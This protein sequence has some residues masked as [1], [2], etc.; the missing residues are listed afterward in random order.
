MLG[1]IICPRC[2]LVQGADLSVA[3]TTCPR[4]QKRIEVRRAKIYF[5]TD[6]PKEL[7]E[8]VRQ[9]GTRLIYDIERPGA[10][11]PVPETM[12]SRADRPDLRTKI[13]EL[14]K[15]RGE[16]TGDEFAR[17]LTCS[18]ERDL[19]SAIASLLGSGLMYEVSAGRYRAA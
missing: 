7:A 2:T 5:S 19:D 1:V 11:D 4:C 6:S 16:A 17:A 9:I 13:I 18:E 8:G 12:P 10:G 15:E 14:L 3:R